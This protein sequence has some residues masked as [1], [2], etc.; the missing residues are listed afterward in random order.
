MEEQKSNLEGKGSENRRFSDS[1]NRR[2]SDSDKLF[3]KLVPWEYMQ[4][5]LSEICPLLSLNRLFVIDLNV[6][7]KMIF[8]EKH[9]AFLESLK[10][11]YRME[12]HFYLTRE[13]TYNSFMTIVRQICK[14]H[15]QP[16]HTELKF[17]RAFHNMVYFIPYEK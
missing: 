13:F 2:F 3:K 16:F 15:K 1:D 7:K 8:L 11:Y 12:K 5:L 10:P 14:S 4:I 9:Y 17:G 6:Y